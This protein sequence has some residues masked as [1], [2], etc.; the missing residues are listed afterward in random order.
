MGAGPE[1]AAAGRTVAS[2]ARQILYN[3]QFQ[4][5]VSELYEGYVPGPMTA[6]VKVAIGSMA[7][8]LL[9]AA[10]DKIYE[11]VKATVPH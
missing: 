11:D 10:A 4:I 1:L 6:S 2:T 7:G 3:P 8:P 9:N 5:D